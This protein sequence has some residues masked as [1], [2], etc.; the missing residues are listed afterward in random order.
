VC[1]YIGKM[2]LSFN[3][4]DGF[5]NGIVRGFRANLIKSNEYVNLTQCETLEGNL[6]EPLNTM[7]L[8]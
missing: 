6:K 5:L 2:S 3:A 8:A 4:D 7:F 1:A